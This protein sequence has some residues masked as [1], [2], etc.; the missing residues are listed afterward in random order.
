MD[1]NQLLKDIAGMDLNGDERCLQNYAATLLISCVCSITEGSLIPMVARHS[2][3]FCPHLRHTILPLFLTNQ[4][5]IDNLRELTSQVLQTCP[6]NC[7]RLACSNRDIH[8]P[9]YNIV[10]HKYFY[11]NIYKFI[12]L[13]ICMR[14]YIHLKKLTETRK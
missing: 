3:C 5:S 9:F 8:S 2:V 7:Q 11:T 10:I 13:Y 4:H 14:A 1:S 6:L 12:Y